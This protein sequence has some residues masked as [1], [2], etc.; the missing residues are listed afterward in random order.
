MKENEHPYTG[1]TVRLHATER[2]AYDLPEMVDRTPPAHPLVIT[3]TAAIAYLEAAPRMLIFLVGIAAGIG[4]ALRL[5]GQDGYLASGA[6]AAV[7]LIVA[8]AYV[9]G[10]GA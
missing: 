9:S 5:L 6:L 2:I 10:R 7:C 3:L 1:Q 8:V 4:G